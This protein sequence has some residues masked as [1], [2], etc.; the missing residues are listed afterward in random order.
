[1][2]E[3]EGKGDLQ[4]PYRDPDHR[5]VA[6]KL[7]PEASPGHQ[8]ENSVDGVEIC[9]QVLWPTADRCGEDGKS[10]EAARGPSNLRRVRHFAIRNPD[11]N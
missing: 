4:G 2:A 3:P 6:L 10:R 9:M 5:P 11:S 8:E 1:L 7:L